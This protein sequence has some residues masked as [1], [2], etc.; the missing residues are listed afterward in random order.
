MGE[1]WPDTTVHRPR[2]HTFYDIPPN[3]FVFQVTQKGLG[4]SLMMAGYCRNM[5]EPVYRIEEWYKSV[6]RVG[7]FYYV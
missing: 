5:L 4:S 2:N 3:I 7:Y 6:H 1:K